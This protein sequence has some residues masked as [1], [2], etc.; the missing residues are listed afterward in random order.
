MYFVF[1]FYAMRFVYYCLID[2]FIFGF[3]ICIDLGD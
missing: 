3:V 2:D 1:G